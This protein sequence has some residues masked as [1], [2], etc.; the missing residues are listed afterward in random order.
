MY[1]TTSPIVHKQW[2][3]V[4]FCKRTGQKTRCSQISFWVHKILT[5]RDYY[6]FI[7]LLMCMSNLQAQYWHISSFSFSCPCNPAMTLSYSC[8]CKVNRIHQS[9]RKSF[10]HT[11]PLGFH[12]NDFDKSNSI[13]IGPH[14]F[15]ST[16]H[17]KSAW[18]LPTP[19]FCQYHFLWVQSRSY[20]MTGDWWKNWEC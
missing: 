4:V 14:Y 5:A 6:L 16:K 1:G 9:S 13:F 18:P 10:W 15:S 19:M 11:G 3:L 2:E 7:D 8:S 20:E 17:P 12:I